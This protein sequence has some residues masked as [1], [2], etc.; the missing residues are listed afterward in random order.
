[1]TGI[2]LTQIFLSSGM[3]FSSSESTNSSTTLGGIGNKKSNIIVKY[4][5]VNKA[6]DSKDRFIAKKK[7]SKVT[8]KKLINRFEMEAL[9]IS[10]DEDVT[11]IIN[12]LQNDPNVEYA[13][14]DYVLDTY[15]TPSDARYS[16]QWGLLNNGQ[17][18]NGQNGISGVD[19][20]AANAWDITTGTNKVVVG[21]VDSGVDISHPDISDNIYVNK[22]EKIDGKDNDGNGFV[23][24]V[25]GFDFANNDS[26]VFDSASQDKHATHIAGIIAA[27][28]NN[29]G[30][31]GVSPNVKLLPLKFISG[32]TGYTSD[33]ISAIEYGISMGVSVF[34][35]SWGGSQQNEALKDIIANSNALFICAAGNQGQN[36]DVNPV[37]P[38]CY[39]LSNV[40]S[41]GAIDNKGELASF[42]NFGSK[43]QIAAPGVGILS[44]LPESKYGLMSGTSMAA[45]FVA[46]VAAL[47]KSK[48]PTMSATDIKT[49]I[50]NNSTKGQALNGKV[51]TSGR[52]NA[53]AALLNNAPS[54][55]VQPTAEPIPTESP[56]SKEAGSVYDTSASGNN[57]VV[58]PIIED[59]NLIIDEAANNATYSADSFEPNNSRNAATVITNDTAIYPT[60]DTSSDEDWFVLNTTKTG[61]LNVTMKNLPSGC[62]YEMEIYDSTGAYVG[63]SYASG[64]LDEKYVGSITAIGNYYIRIYSYSG[65]NSSYTYE[66]KAGVYTPD[67]YEVNDDLY[68]ILNNQPSISIGNCFS[69]TLDNSDDTDCFKFN[70]GNST[71]VGVRVQNIPSGSDY[72]MVVYSYNSSNGFVEV[73]SSNLGGN[74]DETLISQL[75]AGSYY[76]KIYSYSGSSETQSYKLSVT[77][78]NAG[79]VKM[80]FDK[81]YAEVGDIVT[82]TLRV[83]QITNLSA[84]QVNIKYDPQVIQPVD[85]DLQPYCEDTVPT[86]ATILNNSKYSP[87]SIASNNLYSGILNFGAG[88]MNLLSYKQSGIAQTSGILAVI[89]FKVI[90]SKQV[91]IKFSVSDAIPESNTGVNLIDWDGSK[92][93]GGFTVQQPQI[94][95]SSLPANSQ[96]VGSSS[97]EEISSL[98]SESVMTTYSESTYKISGYIKKEIKDKSQFN[99]QFINPTTNALIKSGTTDIDSGYFEISGIPPGNYNVKIS[100]AYHI[101]RII[102]D[103]VVDRD[104]VLGSRQYPLGL[105]IGD[106]NNDAVINMQDVIQI[107]KGFNA[108]IGDTRYSSVCDLNKDDA[109]NMADVVIIATNFIKFPEDYPTYANQTADVTYENDG[110]NGEYI[111]SNNPERVSD[112]LADEGKVIYKTQTH[113][114]KYVTVFMQHLA[115]AGTEKLKFGVLLHNSNPNPVYIKISN[116]MFGGIKNIDTNEVDFYNKKRTEDYK[117]Y[118]G[119]TINNPIN[120]YSGSYSVASNYNG[121]TSI[122]IPSGKSIWLMGGPSTS[123]VFYNDGGWERSFV[124]GMAKFEILNDLILDV[125]VVAY[126]A[127]STNMSTIIAANTYP[128]WDGGLSYSGYYRDS[129]PVIKADITT[130]LGN[131]DVGSYIKFKYKCKHAKDSNTPDPKSN[132][133]K[134]FN[135]LTTNIPLAS[136]GS[137]YADDMLHLTNDTINLK[138]PLRNPVEGYNENW[139][140]WGVVYK[141]HFTFVNN[142]SSTYKI[143]VYMKGVANNPDIYYSH[144]FGNKSF[145]NYKELTPNLDAQR[146]L[147]S[148][149][150]DVGTV[151][152]GPGK[153]ERELRFILPANSGGGYQLYAKIVSKY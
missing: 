16:E 34:N 135:C 107:A 141:D 43:V 151:E 85:D 138:E 131:T 6:K 102:Y 121:T 108:S 98:S 146:Y 69:A 64:A 150:L 75:A 110:A 8:S 76:I 92:I 37:Y 21:I 62:D 9:Q 52:L 32:N 134:I 147:S 13:Q 46:G 60:L 140:N 2:M 149:T 87:M 120:I 118:F 61:K 19:I 70:I 44:T 14:P 36:V 109:I 127:S 82:A 97:V 129:S 99:I 153:T 58:K 1:M 86:G 128:G 23:D 144:N 40:I 125:K 57:K 4:K 106:I 122:T 114:Q 100:N 53:L 33:A 116:H 12:E 55:P 7:K 81:T 27:G 103:L 28:M 105:F 18:V 47:L 71:N 77:D 96:A 45:P 115:N 152:V 31:T 66:L 11:D 133:G 123:E 142:S 25:N 3:A 143:Q 79:I 93:I 113:G 42:S 54:I 124:N 63:G 67:S 20:A 83:N 148:T 30:I 17:A 104:N 22:K 35:C 50:L 111:Y 88:Y 89:K 139:A 136:E 38:A 49:R 51:S 48:Y 65:S 68:S 15:L 29:V 59:S 137:A 145:G 84:Y 78:E 112:R 119:G 41:V 10:S 95:N 5:D 90:N 72:D 130:Y 24:D 80:D 101:T 39:D 26:S 132:S 126:K 73:G 74:S 117:K 94:V 56:K 91:Q